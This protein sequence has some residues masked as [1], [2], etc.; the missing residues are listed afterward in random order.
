[1]LGNSLSLKA[2]D[3]NQLLRKGSRGQATTNDQATDRQATAKAVVRHQ[4]PSNY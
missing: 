4:Q 1:M 3:P 2:R